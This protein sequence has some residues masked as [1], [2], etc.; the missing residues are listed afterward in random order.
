MCA[1]YSSAGLN[2]ITMSAVS[3]SSYKR[4]SVH[5]AFSVER[6]PSDKVFGISDTSSIYYIGGLRSKYLK[7]R[8]W[9]KLDMY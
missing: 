8:A 1:S 5:R 9:L 6:W 2:R 4:N 7:F 3:R